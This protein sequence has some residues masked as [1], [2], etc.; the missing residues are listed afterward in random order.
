MYGR[1]AGELTH[2]SGDLCSGSGSG[3]AAAALKLQPTD[4]RKTKQ[5]QANNIKIQQIN[6]C[7][8]C[9]WPAA[10]QSLLNKYIF[11]LPT[12]IQLLFS[13]G[14]REC[15]KALTLPLKLVMETCSWGQRMDWA[16]QP[17][18]SRKPFSCGAKAAGCD[19]VRLS[20]GGKALGWWST[21]LP[22]MSVKTPTM[23]SN[24]KHSQRTTLK[25]H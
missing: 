4:R 22:L 3:N 21:W 24:F 15:G 14:G 1:D 23:L 2:S 20:D 6:N 19:P 13:L 8:H 5:K 11:N 18:S 17:I 9:Q 25:P 7:E 16:W 12:S 10:P